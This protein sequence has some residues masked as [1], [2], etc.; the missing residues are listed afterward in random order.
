[1]LPGKF[2]AAVSMCVSFFSSV[3]FANDQKP[4]ADTLYKKAEKSI[5]KDWDKSF[6]YAKIEGERKAKVGEPPLS[7]KKQQEGTDGMKMILFNKAVISAVCG[8]ET[9]HASKNVDGAM[10]AASACRDA[11]LAEMV[12][13]VKLMDY[14]GAIGAR[15]LA[16]CE[17]KSRDYKNEIR[18]LPYDFLR[19]SD[20]PK[21]FNFKTFNECVLSDV[22]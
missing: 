3:G 5:R 6:E 10:A 1:M 12:K 7:A 19:N 14:S 20:G 16:N 2:V 9:A 21:L 22:N 15:K 8:E 11:R 18:F 13:S 17:M 4:L